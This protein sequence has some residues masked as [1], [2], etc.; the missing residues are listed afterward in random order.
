MTLNGKTSW[1]ALRAAIDKYDASYD[2]GAGLNDYLSELKRQNPE[3][4]AELSDLLERYYEEELTKG[5]KH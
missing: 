1:S 2:K 3:L 5:I 4:Y